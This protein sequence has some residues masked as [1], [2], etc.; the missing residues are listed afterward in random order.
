MKRI[1]FIDWLRIIAIVMVF[2]FHNSRFFDTMYW[3]VKNPQQSQSVLYFVGF[4]N[5]W[6]MPLFFLLSGAAGIFGISKRFG[7]YLKSKITRLV[8]PYIFGVLVLIPPQKYLEALYHNHYSGGLLKYMTEYFSGGIIHYHMGFTPLWIG[9]LAYHLWFLGFLFLMSVI[10]YPLMRF[11]TNKGEK[12]VGFIYKSTLIPGSTLLYFLPLALTGIL[13]KKSFPQYIDWADFALFTIYFLYGF[14]FIKHE[15]LRRNLLR[16]SIPALITGTLCI[17]AYGLSYS[18][19]GTFLFNLF[20]DTQ[21]YGFYVFHQSVSALTTWSWL[22]FIL[23]LGMRY[24]EKDSVWRESLNEA[25]LPFYILH[26]TII[27]LIGY[28]V[29]QF[30]WNPWLKFALISSSS[31]FVITIIYILVIKPF[32]AARYL[33]GMKRIK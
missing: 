33:F 17:W 29:V 24:L 14:I 5:S 10:L 15:G 26:Q 2:I 32:N 1:Y 19:P 18:F 11:I 27:L 3:H 7:P 23:S 9:T 16:D 22:V 20:Q 28:F 25:V 30:P 6:I 4:L 13:L 21:G 12:I 31:F 8:I